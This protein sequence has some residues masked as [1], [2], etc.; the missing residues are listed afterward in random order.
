VE[1][2]LTVKEMEVHLHTLVLPRKKKR[3]VVTQGPA[4]TTT[5]KPQ[6][7][8]RTKWNPQ[9]TWLLVWFCDWKYSLWS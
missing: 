3:I 9:H 1:E 7:F 5:T 8:P 4:F 6:I 2:V